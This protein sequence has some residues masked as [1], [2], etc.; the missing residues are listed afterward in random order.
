MVARH[1]ADAGRHPL[2]VISFEQAGGRGEVVP[3][4]LAGGGAVISY[5]EI[6]ERK[7]V[8]ADEDMGSLIATDMTRCIHCTRCVRFGQ[9]IAGIMEMVNA[10][11]LAQEPSTPAECAAMGEAIRILATVLTPFAPHLSDEIA[12]HYGATACTVSANWP[13]FDPALVVDDVLPY[14]VQINGKLKAEVRV[15]AAAGE[16]EVRAAAEADEKVKAALAGKT[17]KK[18]VFVPKRLINIVVV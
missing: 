4:D 16:N 2:L 10:L 18:V 3:L 13:A 17:V 14:A 6:T 7:R 5:T 11:Y 15:A 12:Q 8:V 9:E 1:A